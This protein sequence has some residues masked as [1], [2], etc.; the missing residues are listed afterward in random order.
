MFTS[1]EEEPPTASKKLKAIVVSDA[2]VDAS[3]E[4]SEAN[5]EGDDNGSDESDEIESDAPVAEDDL[6][7][8][9]RPRAALVEFDQESCDECITRSQVCERVAGHWRCK[10]CEQS[11]GQPCRF[12]GVSRQGDVRGKLSTFLLVRRIANSSIGRGRQARV[13]ARYNGKGF[14]WHSGATAAEMTEVGAIVKKFEAAGIK[15]TILDSDGL[16]QGLRLY[17]PSM[18]AKTDF[19]L[20]QKVIGGSGTPASSSS[21]VAKTTPARS[22]TVVNS[23]KGKVRPRPAGRVDDSEVPT[24]GQ[25]DLRVA[26]LRFAMNNAIVEQYRQA[27]WFNALADREK[28]LTG[29]EAGQYVSTGGNPVPK[30]RAREVVKSETVAHWQKERAL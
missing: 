18:A 6:S 12:S 24:P 15:V 26:E 20:A 4:S 17:R 13:I 2:E 19:A 27:A 7:W 10:P 23:A 3:S 29:K 5:E 8:A 11:G 1:S 22:A 16:Q 30:L 14:S 9:K 28:A 21:R 25:L